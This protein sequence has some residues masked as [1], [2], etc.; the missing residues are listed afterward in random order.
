MHYFRHPHL[1]A[2][3]VIAS[4]L[5]TLVVL[6]GTSGSPSTSGRIKVPVSTHYVIAQLTSSM[7]QGDVLVGSSQPLGAWAHSD[8][9][10]ALQGAAASRGQLRAS[11]L[12]LAAA[13]KNAEQPAGPHAVMFERVMGV[14]SAIDALIGASTK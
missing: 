12:A 5:L 14:G 3:T 8:R 1:A 9:L 6:V 7:A 11:F 13:A 10:L 2:W 4:V